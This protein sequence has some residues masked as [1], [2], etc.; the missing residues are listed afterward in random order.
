M[1]DSGDIFHL[2][3]CEIQFRL[4]SRK[5]R[6]EKGGG[7]GVDGGLVGVSEGVSRFFFLVIE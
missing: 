4:V 2:N 6:R 5:T 3:A 1:R 7:Q